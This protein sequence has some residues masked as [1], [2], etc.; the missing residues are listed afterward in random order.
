MRISEL[1]DRSG[2]STATIKFYLREGLLHGGAKITPRLT[3]YDESHVRRLGLL[4]VLREVGGVPIDRLRSLVA[5]AESEAASRHEMLGA[6]ADALVPTPAPAGPARASSRLVADEVVAQAG[7]HNVRANAPDRENLAAVLETI[8]RYGTHTDDPAELAAYI[9]SAD[10]IARYEIG[11]LDGC[12]DRAGLLEEMVVGQ[13]V[14]GQL[15]NILRRLA[16]EHHS[17]ERFG[18]APAD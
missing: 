11:H 17:L 12:K 1:S 7:W 2:I 8:A 16:E 18:D 4:R 5:V 14:F 3:D 15:L 9:R 10:Q 6:A 13:V